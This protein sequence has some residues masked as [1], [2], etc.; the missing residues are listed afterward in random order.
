MIELLADRSH[1]GLRWTVLAW[2]VLVVVMV[3]GVGYVLL[4]LIL[5]EVPLWVAL[6]LAVVAML[7][8]QPLANWGEKQLVRRWPSGRSVRLEAAA[9]IVK[10]KAGERRFDLG[11]PVTYQRWRFEIRGR[12]GSRISSGSRCFAIRLGQGEQFCSLYAFLP[13][14]QAEALS[15]RFAFYE[16]RRL[17]RSNQQTGI[18][19]DPAFLMAESDRWMYGAELEPAALETALDHLGKH[20]EEF[21]SRTAG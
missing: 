20:V 5:G 17:D 6:V 2:W 14:A 15:R 7:A 9:C 8:S 13:S 21:A 12:R 1:T 3:W 18:G 11:Q 10:E 16:L 19:R 4:G